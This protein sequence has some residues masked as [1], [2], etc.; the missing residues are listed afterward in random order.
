MDPRDVVE[1]LRDGDVVSGS[2]LAERY[3]VSRNAVWKHVESLRREGFE[4]ESTGSGYRLDGV[5]EY[6]ANAVAYHLDTEYV[7][8]EIEYHDV[9]ESTNALAREAAR[10][11]ADE[12]YTVLADRQEGGKGRRGRRWESPSGGVWTSVVLRPELSPR[13]ASVVTLAASVAVADAL[14]DLGVVVS[15]KWPNDVLAGDQK[16]CGV[17]VEFEADAE[18]V[19][20]FVVGLG[21][22]ANAAPDVDGATSLELELGHEVDRARLTAALYRALEAWLDRPRDDILEEWRRRSSTLGRLVRVTTAEDVFEGRATS[23]DDSG[24]LHVETNEGERVV[25]AAD[26]EHLR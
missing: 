3:G 19:S 1:E 4:I 22:N 10:A 2:A 16:V 12:G 7:G 15:I 20:Y 17:L 8:D 5:P 21:L 25:T 13:E 14:D 11:D 26:C 24:A 9:V 6:G 18:E 23:I